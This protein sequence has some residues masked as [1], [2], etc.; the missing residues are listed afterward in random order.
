M[1]NQTDFEYA[2]ESTKIV[3]P[4]SRRIQTFGNT[5]FHFVLVSE[6]LDEVNQVRVRNG[7]IHAQK[8]TL[9]TPDSISKLMLD[10]FGEQASGFADWLKTT[11]SQLSFLKYGFEIRK[12][13]VNEVVLHE[14]IE[15]VI[16]RICSDMNQADR[17]LEV[18]IQ[19]V[20]DAWEVCL[21]KFTVDL[22]QES[23]SGNFGDLRREGLL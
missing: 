5:R 20:D 9:I 12:T 18:L 2:V 14:P 23:A 8:P 13:N 22:I 4:P 3:R 19:G 17:P 21:L 16:G 11:S 7:E 6:L 1:W 15:S 10:G